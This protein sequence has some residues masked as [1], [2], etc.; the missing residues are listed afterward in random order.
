MEGWG[1]GESVKGEQLKFTSRLVA[2]YC[3]QLK[4][5]RERERLGLCRHQCFRSVE[6]RTE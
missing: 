4:R 2:V 5:E 1:G 6:Q 3:N